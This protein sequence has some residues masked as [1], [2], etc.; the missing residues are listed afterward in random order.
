MIASTI[1]LLGFSA[2]VTSVAVSDNL[3]F[4]GSVDGSIRVWIV[5]SGEFFKSLLGIYNLIWF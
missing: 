1:L 2:G 5:S 3:L 4:V